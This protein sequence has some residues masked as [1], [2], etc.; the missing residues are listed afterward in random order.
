MASVGLCSSLLRDRCDSEVSSFTA[1]LCV[2]ERKL[3]HARRRLAQLWDAA[4]PAD[5]IFA[6]D[7]LLRDGSLP[8]ER[9]TRL[10]T[11]QHL[12]RE[13][14]AK[15]RLTQRSVGDPSLDVR[16]ASLALD[17]AERARDE[18][19]VEDGLLDALFFAA[20]GYVHTSP[21]HEPTFRDLWHAREVMLSRLMPTAATMNEALHEA[22]GSSSP[23]DKI[24][25]PAGED[26]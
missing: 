15:H 2:V 1:A 22:K 25:M 14:W 20:E 19:L 12:V 18:V 3:A 6:V 9:A 8:P 4:R 17:L 24:T 10:R 11:V 23:R 16:I 13:A 21:R 26:A 5:R 7:R